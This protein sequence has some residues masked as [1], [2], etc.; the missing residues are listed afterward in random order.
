MRNTVFT[1][2]NAELK[3]ALKISGLST[4]VKSPISLVKYYVIKNYFKSNIIH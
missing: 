4:I 3:A 1:T 2:I